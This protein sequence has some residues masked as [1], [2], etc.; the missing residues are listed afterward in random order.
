[1][2]KTGN[3][4]LL[5]GILLI[6]SCSDFLD[7]VPKEVVTEKDVWENIKNAEK[8][9]AYLYSVLPNEHD[10]DVF[11]ASDECWHH[12]ESTV[13]N[14]WKYNQGSWGPTDNPFGVWAGRYEDI[15]KA[16]LFIENIES[17][18]LLGDQVAYYAERVPRFKAEARFM[19]ALYYFELLK[20]YGPVPLITESVKIEDINNPSLT[21]YPRNSVD[22]VVNFIV[23]EC[24]EIKSIL[25]VDYWDEPNEMGRI[26]RG[27]ALALKSRTLLY[28]ASPLLNGNTMYTNIKNKDGKELF[29]V[30]D[31]EKWKLAA[32]AS[33]ELLLMVDDDVYALNQ[34]N[35]DEPT[36]NYARLFYDRE[37]KETILAK[38]FANSSW[39]EQYHFPNGTAFGGYGAISVFQELV[40]A[41]ETT[42]GLPVKE[43]PAY[44]E[45]GFWDGTMWDGV[46]RSNM[47]NVSNMYKDR[48]PRFYATVYF[49]YSNWVLN[50]HGRPINYAYYGYSKNG[51]L[52]DG[53]PWSSGT[54]NMTGY[55]LRKWNS[56]EVDLV[57]QSG[58]ARRNT[59]VFRLAEIYLD[60]AEALNEYLDA[61]DQEIYDA[62][63][64]VR[65]RV[66]MPS[67]PL[68][69]RPADRTKEG[70][71]ERIHNERRVELAFEGHR[72]W[73]TRRWLI[74]ADR[75]GVKGTDNQAM[76]GLNNRPTQDE[77]AST[78]L[79]INSEAAGVAVFYKRT[80]AQTRVFE[81][82]HYLFPIPQTELDKNPNLVQNYGW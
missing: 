27:A 15:R 29:P 20:R 10:D 53:W 38:T 42:N 37:W 1:M 4:F 79:D 14:A 73:D 16:N 62:V 12:W 78:G 49:Q 9:L 63:N 56:P 18:P 54:H 32:D 77:L 52:S 7:V 33:K 28:A 68:A 11:G 76:Y 66:S 5:L 41:Y 8:A 82:K 3:L 25:K 51:A 31:H 17:V 45:E 72:F 81:N 44:T 71:R 67:L 34:P 55:G 69:S 36:D 74:A 60:Y 24:D 70:M 13:Q 30:Y 26:T 59:P 65:S 2:K 80:V 75:N 39:F 48:D 47:Y 57:N 64:V 43:D 19:R 50:R 35:P 22:E 46:R 6:H 40:D 23:S 58:T 21:Q 61:P